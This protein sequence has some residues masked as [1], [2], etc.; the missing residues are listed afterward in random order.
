VAYPVSKA[1][2]DMVTVRYA[3]AFPAM[4]INA[5]EPG[6]TRTDLNL[7]TGSQPVEEGAEVIVRMAQVGPDGPT[8]GLF[9]VD[10][11]VPW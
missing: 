6:F 1:A 10:G 5:V 2:V 4:R 11:S 3:R 9:D 7:A 8:G